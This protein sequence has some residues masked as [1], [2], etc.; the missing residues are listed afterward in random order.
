M[1]SRQLTPRQKSKPS[2][3][4]ASAAS[5][6]RTMQRPCLLLRDWAPDSGCVF[7]VPAS[8]TTSRSRSMASI[9]TSGRCAQGRSAIRSAG[10]SIWSIASVCSAFPVQRKSRCCDGLCSNPRRRICHRT[11]GKAFPRRS[12]PDYPRARRSRS[13]RPSLSHRSR[14]GRG[15]ALRARSC[16]FG[17]R[18]GR[19]R[20][21][22]SDPSAARLSHDAAA[23]RRCRAG[24]PDRSFHRS[25]YLR[26]LQGHPG[27]PDPRADARLLAPLAAGRRV[28]GRGLCAGTGYSGCKTGSSDPTVSDQLAESARPHPRASSPSRRARRHSRFDARAAAVSCRPSTQAAE[29]RALRHRG[30]PGARL[31][32][33]AR[34]QFRA[35]DGQR[36]ASGRSTGPDAPP[37]RHHLQ[38]RPRPRQ[39]DRSHLQGERAGAG[40]LRHLRLERGE[41]DCRGNARSRLHPAQSASGRQRGIRPLSHRAGRKLRLLHPLQASALC[42]VPVEPG[43]AAP[44]QGGQEYRHHQTRR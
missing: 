29:P 31:C 15:L 36:I 26:C 37:L 5:P 18:P 16:R 33:H 28:E 44:G 1:S 19:R 25:P 43:C 38:C 24:R 22:R 27:R 35:S 20:S 17:T 21:L 23:Y 30:N 9:P 13:D 2:P 11:G 42:H 39:P 12:W 7:P 34:L 40:L 4:C 14:H 6:I 32:H 8:R 41:G 3:R 10:I